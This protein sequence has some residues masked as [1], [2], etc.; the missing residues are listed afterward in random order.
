MV[1]GRKTSGLLGGTLALGVVVQ[2]L[3]ADFLPVDKI[4]RLMPACRTGTLKFSNNPQRFVGGL[5]VGDHLSD[6]EREGSAESP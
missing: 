3:L 4:T 6:V 5:Q 1:E 2:R